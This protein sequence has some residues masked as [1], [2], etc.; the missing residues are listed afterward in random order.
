MHR[1]FKSENVIKIE[2]AVKIPDCVISIPTKSLP[3]PKNEDNTEKYDHILEQMKKDNEKYLQAEREKLLIEK[4]AIL[5]QAEMEASAI[6]E[7]AKKEYDECINQAH[8]KSDE[9][10]KNAYDDGF[11]KGIEAKADEL[12]SYMSKLENL[13]EELKSSQEEYFNIY[14]KELKSLA[15]DIAEKIVCQKLDEDD[16]MI[17]SMVKSAIKSIRDA[18][19]IK[20]EISDKL[21][22]IASTLENSLSE[23]RPSQNIEVE[24]RRDAPK[25]TC[26][27]H[28]AEGV[29]VASVLTQIE[30]IRE[31]FSKYKDSDEEYEGEYVKSGETQT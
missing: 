7:N 25:G 9:I 12:N 27:V 29:I 11:R 22:N 2:E 5:K 31:Y 18:K 13:L 14:S 23:G 30:N 19:W 28:T 24:L 4:D 21:K 17:F 10:C 1:I 26:V 8:K 16:K 15:I 6:K 3:E 20:V